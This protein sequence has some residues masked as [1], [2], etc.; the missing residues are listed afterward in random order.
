MADWSFLLNNITIYTTMNAIVINIIAAVFSAAFAV[1]TYII[2]RRILL[3]GQKEEIIKKA[4][5]EAE[6][7]K[8]EKIFQA[9]EK[10]LQLKSEHENYINEKN[11]HI[12]ETESRLKQKENSLNQQNAE[13][14]RKQ[15]EA[16]AIRENLKAQVEIATKKANEYDKLK[17]DALRQ[18]EEIAGMTAVEAKNQLMENMKAEAKTQAQSYINDMMDEARLTASKEAKRIV[19]NTIQR[20]ASET[21][22]EN[23]VT[24]FHIESDE[25]KGRIIGREGRNIRALEAATGVEI[26][27]DDTPEAILLSAFDPVRREVARLALHQLVIDGRIHPARIEEVVDKVQKQLEEEII[28]TGKRTCID[29]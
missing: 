14:G 26:V 6:S 18:I 16:D 7:I 28:E 20:T 15:K 25:I 4:E 10:F 2:I 24:V 11:N 19:I 17:Q 21:A 1:A 13:L 12:R 27:V 8:K 9:K 23:A 3:K 29:L 5:L 22:I